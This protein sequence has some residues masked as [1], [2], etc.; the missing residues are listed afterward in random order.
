MKINITWNTNLNENTERTEMYNYKNEEDFKAFKELTENNDELLHCFDDLEEDLNVSANRW[1][2]TLNMLIK[3]S[4]KR[5]RINNKKS[6][7]IVLDNLLKKKE[8][9]KIQLAQFDN[10]DD[11]EKSEDTAEALEKV[12][13]DISEVCAATNKRIVDE[14]LGRHKD[15]LEGFNQNKTWTMKKVWLLKILL[16]ILLQKRIAMLLW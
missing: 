3:K 5:I 7:N 15:P 8:E 11:I 6:P 13:E 16:I 2:S 4:F 14:H 10:L 9:I 1:M 12:L